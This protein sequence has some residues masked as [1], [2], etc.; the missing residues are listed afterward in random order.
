MFIDLGFLERPPHSDP[1]NPS[2]RRR[3]PA[4]NAEATLCT[5]LKPEAE[6]RIR[7][8]GSERCLTLF[9]EILEDM[10]VG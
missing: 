3:V 4:S 6:L 10:G 8:K 7:G 1:S 5:H 9:E 2:L